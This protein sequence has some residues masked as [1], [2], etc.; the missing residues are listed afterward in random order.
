VPAISS[1]VVVRPVAGS[2]T[3]ALTTVARAAELT[4]TPEP[5][6]AADKPVEASTLRPGKAARAVVSDGRA[7]RDA[8]KAVLAVYLRR[9]QEDVL[10]ELPDRLE[11]QEW[12]ALEGAA[13]RAYRKAVLE[14]NFRRCAGPHSTRER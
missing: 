9:N 10:S 3:E 13:M 5:V 12:V 4:R 2:H 6:T 8:I 11:T 7:V 14:G 1:V